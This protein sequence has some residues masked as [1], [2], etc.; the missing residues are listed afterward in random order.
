MA[1]RAARDM[2]IEEFNAWCE[3]QRRVADA[4]EAS[5]EEGGP[6]VSLVPLPTSVP[7]DVL[8]DEVEL[9][10]D[11]DEDR[12]GQASSPNPPRLHA[13]QFEP[14]PSR[15][16]GGWSADRQPY[17]SNLLPRPD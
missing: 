1:S 4:K 2:T 5:A 7:L 13:V 16:V 14:E 11:T 17:L 6:R 15:R 3:G 9:P 12:S 8:P 10:A